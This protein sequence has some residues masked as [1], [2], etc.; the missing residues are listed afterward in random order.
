MKNSAAETGRAARIISLNISDSNGRDQMI[1]YKYIARPTYAGPISKQ[2]APSGTPDGAEL[3]ELLPTLPPV[4]RECLVGF[5]HSM[6]VF[7]LLD[8]VAFALAGRDH[9]GGELLGH[10]LLVAAA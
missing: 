4:V 9:F 7:L 1:R 3:Q 6:R 5:G 10:R 8:R 2:K